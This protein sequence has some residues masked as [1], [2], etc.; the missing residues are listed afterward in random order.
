MPFTLNLTLKDLM[1]II[2]S[3]LMITLL[4]PKILVPVLIASSGVPANY[5][6]ASESR[7][8]GDL[9]NICFE[10]IARKSNLSVDSLRLD[11]RSTAYRGDRYNVHGYVER[12]DGD[13][14]FQC[15]FAANGEFESSQA[16]RFSLQ[17]ASSK[18]SSPF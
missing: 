15:W 16:N 13:Y 9:I 1:I 5:V 12:N 11:K 2:G 14:D 17:D 10:D 4:L 18:P 3:A 6:E 7:A 8:E